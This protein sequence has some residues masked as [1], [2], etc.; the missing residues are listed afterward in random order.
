MAGAHRIKTVNRKD[1]LELF[2]AQGDIAAADIAAQIRLSIPTIMKVL[3]YLLKSRY[4]VPV[5]KRTSTGAGGKRPSVF[6]FNAQRGAAIGLHVTPT[7]MVGVMTD[8]RLNVIARVSV[9]MEKDAGPSAAVEKMAWACTELSTRTATSPDLIGIG[10]AFP[11]IVDAERGWVRMS[12][13]FPSWSVNVDL[14]G[15]L[16]E[17]LGMEVPVTVDNESRFQVVAE[18]EAGVARGRQHAVVLQAG[19][20]VVAGILFQNELVRGVHHLAGEIGHMVIEPHEE[21]PCACGGKGCFEVMVSTRRL[22]AMARERRA[23]FSAS[24]LRASDDLT[25]EEIFEAANQGDANAQSLL[26]DVIGWFAIGISN[27]IMMYDPEIIVLNGPY[28]RAGDYFLHNLRERVNTISLLRIDKEVEIAYTAFSDDVA[29]IGAA[30]A[31]VSEYFKTI[32]L[33]T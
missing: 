3:D 11:G 29:V 22:L 32:V 10:I 16:R 12:P 25:P 1:V 13:H 26:D 28:T 4:I 17:R 5:G 31:I 8:L 23:R 7:E 24:R 30:T 2:R 15:M 33:D 9:P 21:T 14:R 20:G 19:H 6:R 27:L 18:R